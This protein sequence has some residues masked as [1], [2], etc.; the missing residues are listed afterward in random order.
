MSKKEA[1]DFDKEEMCYRLAPDIDTVIKANER[2]KLENDK[3]RILLSNKILLVEDGSVN[4]DK[5]EKDGFYVICYR[6]GSRAPMWLEEK[7]EK[8]Y[9]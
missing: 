2:L 5:L 3:F 4:T 8:V 7:E 6:H 1:V 9:D